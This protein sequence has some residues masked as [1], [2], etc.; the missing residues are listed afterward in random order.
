M[1]TLSFTLVSEGSSDRVLIPIL[2]WM[3]FRHHREYAWTGQQANLQDLIQPPRDLADKIRTASTLFPADV[4]F[5][6]RDADNE[7]PSKRRQEI[8][9]AV[10]S[11]G[12]QH[13]SHL[14][15]VVPIRMTEA[16]L[17]ISEKAL[18]SAAGNPKG[19]NRLN[20]PK[21]STLENIPDP[22][23]LL[24]TLLIDASGL[25]GRRKKKLNFSTQRSRI[26]DFFE[27]WETLLQLPSA[28]QLDD[29]ISSLL[30]PASK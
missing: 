4:I 30:F 24:Q 29:E 7:T 2:R 6:H 20:C 1:T 3:L 18:R 23:K 19:R 17:L 14:V 28:K 13:L 15:P 21:I 10:S 27:S 9:D 5:V 22:K 25:S 12:E 8:A 26:P 11:I 16:W